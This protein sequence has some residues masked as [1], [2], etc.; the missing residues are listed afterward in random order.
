MSK[1]EN[2]DF[3]FEGD[4]DIF[5]GF[6]PDLTSLQKKEDE[7]TE[8]S[9]E[10]EEE[11]E[12]KIPSKEE[13][14]EEETGES[15]E[16]EVEE[17][18]DTDIQEPAEGS[19]DDSG[20]EATET[21]VESVSYRAIADYLAESGIIDGLGEDFEGEDTP[22]VLEIAVQK[23][24]ENLVTSY[25]E[26]IPEVGKQFLDYVEKGGDPSK[27]FQALEKPIDFDTL[28]LTDEKNQKRVY[29][30]YLKSL[31][32]TPEEI[33]E[34]L[35]DTEDNLL[36]EKKSKVAKGK[37]EKIHSEKQ[38]QLV[39]QQEQALADQQ[40]QY[41]EYIN[42]I[43]ETISSSSNIAGLTVSP[44]DKKEFERYLLE[45]D[46]EGLTKYSRELNEDPVKTQLELAYLKFKKYDFSKVVKQAK[47]EA[48]RQIRGI[49]KNSD[50]TAARS[51]QVVRDNKAGDLS[52]FK[53]QL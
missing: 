11:E 2:L 49:I 42:T 27:F 4:G 9:Q 39:A 20:E 46:N 37:L 48:T 29:E 19:D 28:D 41:S 33:K 40:A 45:T 13:G 5:G 24:A 50:K 6:A 15:S 12:V 17:D 25:K 10:T 52:A 35:Q 26:S 36:L 32:W 8:G 7:P 18:A 21:D 53:S 1:T 3:N 44:S 43:K 47:T 51:P 23:T 30:E 38:A 31:E 14:T 16:E 34:E 22:E